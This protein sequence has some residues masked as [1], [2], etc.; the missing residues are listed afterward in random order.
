MKINILNKI[1]I[2][3]LNI[4]SDQ[5]GWLVEVLSSSDVNNRPFGLIH[6]TTAKPGFI[7]GEHYHKRKTEWFCV[8]KGEGKLMLR[9]LDT[10]KTREIM[11]GEDSMSIVEIPP[12]IF[13]SIKNIG[14]EDLYLL[15]YVSESF[16]PKDP[17]T[18][19]E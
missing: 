2:K 15:A 4:K 10:Q 17:D 13:H 8:I 7:K 12:Y 19:K 5:R 3:K 16:D 11:L 1:K 14:N 6:V 9:D 18:F